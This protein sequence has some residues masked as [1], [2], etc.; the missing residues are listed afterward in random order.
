MQKKAQETF[1]QTKGKH[2]GSKKIMLPMTS[3]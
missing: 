1:R 3:V 2:N